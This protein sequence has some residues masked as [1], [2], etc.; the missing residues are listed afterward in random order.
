MQVLSR[1]MVCD[2][3]GETALHVE[4]WEGDD[5]ARGLPLDLGR[6]DCGGFWLPLPV[7]GPNGGD[8]HE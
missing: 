3:C 2:G 5:Y 6:C 7:P 1:P 8:A 4:M